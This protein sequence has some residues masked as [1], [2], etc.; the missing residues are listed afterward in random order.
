M[1]LYT[2]IKISSPPFLFSCRER[3]L[4]LGSCFAENMGT[5]LAE[6]KFN[7]DINPFGTLYNPASIAAAVRLLLHPQQFTAGDLFCHE[8]VYHS[9]THHSRFSSTSEK[10]C[11]EYING[12]LSTSAEAFRRTGYLV[13][14]WGTAYVY[15]LKNT[16]EV[17]ANCHKLPEK[18]FERSMLT[19]A[20]IVAEWKELLLSV[21]EQTPELK[22]LLTVSPIRH[23]KDGAHGNQLSKAT[24]LL[25]ADELQKEYPE[26][27]A[28]FPAYEIMMDE[29]RDYRF[30]A[31]DMLHP[32][33][34]AVDYIWQRFTENYLSEETKGFLKEWAE[35]QK[36]INH[37]P[38]QPESEAYRR[39]M[40]QTLLK[41]ERVNEKF[42]FFDMAKEME[43][44]KSKLM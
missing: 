36:A 37:R 21:W 22:V 4:L 32:S 41:M 33:E 44:I 10:E 6:N 25:A 12:R 2:A 3:M 38:F 43:M 16:G 27:V 29:L 15:R 5:R 8:G 18:M 13:A 11:L 23:W 39:F 42:P 40:S 20:D 24:L 35:I 34:L 28:Y 19:V 9:F 1:E 31:T 30:Y 14:T 7:V 26:R 17:V